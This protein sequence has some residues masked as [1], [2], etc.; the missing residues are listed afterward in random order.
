MAN[1][2][3]YRYGDTKPVMAAVDSATVIEIGDLVWLDTDDAKPAS[4]VTDTETLAGNQEAFHDAFLGVAEQASAAG[5]TDE[6]RV[7]TGGVFEYVCAAE[8]RPL[9]QLVGVIEAASGT[10]LVNQSVDNV[11]TAN[12]AIGRVAKSTTTTTVLVDIVSTVMAGGPQ[13]MA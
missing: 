5:D 10:A 9:G 6:V 11:A 12:L 13:A 4:D 7:A 1:S 8:T 3:R 2:F